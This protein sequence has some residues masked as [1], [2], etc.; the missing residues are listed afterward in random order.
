MPAEPAACSRECQ[1]LRWW[2]V[3]MEWTFGERRFAVF[4]GYGWER[5]P[6]CSAEPMHASTRSV[7]ASMC[8]V[9]VC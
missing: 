6:D 3:F 9:W 5:T 4:C 7:A 2:E 8:G 1:A